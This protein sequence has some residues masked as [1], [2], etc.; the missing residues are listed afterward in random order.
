MLNGRKSNV[1]IDVAQNRP[2]RLTILIPVTS[3]RCSASACPMPNECTEWKH[4]L[5]RPIAQLAAWE[6][7]A[8]GVAFRPALAHLYSGC[9]FHDFF[10]RTPGRHESGR[11]PGVARAGGGV[12]H[13]DTMQAFGAGAGASSPCPTARSSAD[14]AFRRLLLRAKLSPHLTGPNVQDNPWIS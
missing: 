9:R 1:S 10:T 2:C 11:G 12:G 3:A 7:P 14:S 4:R 6:A 8:G 13:T 5:K